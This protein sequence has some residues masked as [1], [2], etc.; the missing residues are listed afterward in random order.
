MQDAASLPDQT[1]VNVVLT[2]ALV[3]LFPGARSE[4][5]ISAGTVSELLDKLDARW[6][7]MRDRLCD[8][9]PQIRRHVNIFV[10]GERA[11]LETRLSPGTEVF[12]IPAVSGG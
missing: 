3:S 1:T 5:Q 9:T 12:V 2:S 11:V 7:G 10:D 4:L 6:P 8:S